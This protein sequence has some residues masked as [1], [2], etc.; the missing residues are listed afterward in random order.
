MINSE[1]IEIRRDGFFTDLF[2]ELHH[3]RKRWN[4]PKGTNGLKVFVS[5]EQKIKL[6]IAFI[7]AVE[8][9]MRISL[10]TYVLQE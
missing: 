8:K 7:E 9:F 4:L 6:N 3:L 10:D 1:D 2:I 5:K